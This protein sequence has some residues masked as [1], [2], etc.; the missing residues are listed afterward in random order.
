MLRRT[1]LVSVAGVVTLALGASACGGGNG[2]GSEGASGLSGTITISGSSTVQPISGLVAELFNET[3]PDVAISV[4]GPGTGDGFALFCAGETDVSDASRPIDPEEAEACADSGVEY[5]ELEIGFDGIT[6]VTN[7]QNTVDCLTTGD[8]YALF[9]PESE[10][11]ASWADANVLASEVGGNGGFSD[12]PLF[13]TAPGPESGTYDAFI[14]LSGIAD[15]GVERGLSEADA[16]TL[17]NDYQASPKD[18]V[19]I[20]AIEGSSSALGFV[21]YAFAE[22]A[23]EAVKEVA[24]DA[25]A[26]CVPPGPEAIA[27]ASYPL[28]RSLYIYVNT[29]RVAQSPALAAFID[30]YVSDLGLS[31]V[32]A[33]VGYVPLPADRIEA[34]RSTWEG[35]AT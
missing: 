24:I 29:G 12:E 11:F 1:R 27:D 32:V 7:P 34:T 22:E 33:E 14:E 8:L 6:V 35:V 4:D 25:G 9:G 26:G 2:G 23:G 21:G 19:I 17:R 28:S 13:I 30:S 18:T 5:V 16:E 10:G 3:N 31:E 20:Q 15:L